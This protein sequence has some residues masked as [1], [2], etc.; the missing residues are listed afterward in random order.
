MI[1]NINVS[2]K[3]TLLIL[4]ITVVAVSAI[5][6][7]GYDYQVKAAR[8]KHLTSLN[9]V[10]DN[11]ANYFNTFFY[12]GSLAVEMLQRSDAVKNHASDSPS[13][14]FMI[15]S[16]DDE[17]S[18]DDSTDSTSSEATDFTSDP[19]QDESTGDILA[20]S[21]EPAGD[22]NSYLTD[23]KNVLQVD[24]IIITNPTGN[25]IASTDPEY[26]TNFV[27][28]DGMFAKAMNGIY[29]SLVERNK[30]TRKYSMF[31]AGS[32][33]DAAGSDMIIIVK[34]DLSK[35]YEL[36][37]NYKGLGKTGEIVLARKGA[38][39]GKIALVSP[40]REDTTAAIRMLESNDPFVVS[41]QPVFEGKAVTQKSKD[42]AGKPVLQTARLIDAADIALIAKMDIEEAEADT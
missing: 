5:S 1:K 39:Q 33:K 16:F 21:S 38:Y 35:P 23:M 36:L 17:S 31:V 10:A 30:E 24:E 15:A 34:L 41:F 2:T 8:E 32:A 12:R 7:F 22:L 14:G 42:Y 29:F 40:I 27:E 19:G 28:R 26:K 6:F 20:T 18:A 13:G 11:Y 37:T 4:A 3:I 9:A 25:V